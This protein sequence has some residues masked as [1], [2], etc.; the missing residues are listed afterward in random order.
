MSTSRLVAAL[1]GLLE[2]GRSAEDALVAGLSAEER[3]AAGTLERWSAK[4]LI[5]HCTSWRANLIATLEAALRGEA[6][7]PLSNV[8]EMNARTF[9]DNKARSWEEVL[10]EAGAGWDRLA[11]LIS[12]LEDEDLLAPD[13]YPWRRGLPLAQGVV[14]R[15]YWHPLVHL[16]EFYAQRGNRT[17]AEAIRA[18]LLQAADELAWVP[19][20][21][22]HTLYMVAGCSAALK[23]PA[24]AL[25]ALRESI[26]LAPELK[27]WSRRDPGLAFVRG[28]PEYDALYQ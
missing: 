24:G 27:E 12:Q 13:H 1:P 20:L 23:D 21:R 14:L 10:S 15:L 18:D 2:R 25:A 9:E 28:T 8:N 11:E 5:A 16:G 22:G 26:A 17:A 3:D 4:D 7:P 19:W 6:P